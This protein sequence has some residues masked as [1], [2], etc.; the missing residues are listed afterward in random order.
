MPNLHYLTVQDIL[1]IN[2]QATQ[3]VQH[4]DYAKLEEATFYQYAYGESSSL[5]PQAGRFLTGFLKMAPFKVASNEATAFIGCLTFLRIN[6]APVSLTDE[7]ALEWM[8]KVM[9]KQLSG[10]E[11][12]KSIVGEAAGH[13][14]DLKPDIK[15][16]VRSVVDSFPKT[17][18]A[19]VSRSAMAK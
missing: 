18:G 2:L 11:A 17:L 19:L 1:W 13:H 12:V 10:V 15:S 5:A 14:H 4:F 9:T 8:D 7:S 6:G 3:K 16:N